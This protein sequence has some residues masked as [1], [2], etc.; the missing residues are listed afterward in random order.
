MAPRKRSFGNE[1]ILASRPDLEFDL[2]QLP[3]AGKSRLFNLYRDGTLDQIAI[4]LEIVGTGTISAMTLRTNA[5]AALGR[6]IAREYTQADTALRWLAEQDRDL[7]VWGACVCARE[8]LR[9]AGKPRPSRAIEAAEGWLAGTTSEKDVRETKDFSYSYREADAAY[10]AAA[11]VSDPA[12]YAPSAAY[13]ASGASR[14]TRASAAELLRLV[15]V[16]ADALPVM[17]VRVR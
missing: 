8:A 5:L 14:T 6:R 9:S 16:I 10:Y 13:Y 7:G 17:P 11:A 12:Y 4:E 2:D 3:R 1:L 15:A